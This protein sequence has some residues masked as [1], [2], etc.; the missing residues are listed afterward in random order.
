M[1][2]LLP[3]LFLLFIPLTKINGQPLLAGVSQV[4]ITPPVGYPHYRDFGTAVHDSLY[5]KAIVF[6]QGETA[7]AIAVCDLLWI[8]RK[9]SSEVRMAV[10]EKTGIPFDHILITATHTHTGPAYHSNIFELNNHLRKFEGTEQEAISRDQYPEK[11]VQNIS[12][13]LVKAYESAVPA[14]VRPYEDTLINL[15]FNRRYVM[16]DGKVR[17]NPG[18]GNREIVK[19]AGPVDPVL[20]ILRVERLDNQSLMAVI[21]NFAV[22]SD[23]FG[24]TQFSADYPGVL[25]ARLKETLGGNFVSIFLM[26]AS[27]DIN[28]IDVRPNGIKLTTDVIG[29][30]LADKVVQQFRK[31]SG[32]LLPS[33]GARSEFVYAPLQAYSE[34][35][36]QWAKDPDAPAKYGE[37]GL[38][39][40]RRPMKIR[41]LERIRATEAVP[42]TIDTEPWVLPVEVQVF[43][44]S[45]QVAVVGLPGEIFAELG[46]QI[47]QQ[48]P[49][50]TTLVV[51]LTNSHIAY[52]PTQKAFPQGGYETLNSRLAPGGGERMVQSAL[53]QLQK[54]K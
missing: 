30:R 10:A 23:T 43:K 47:K 2:Y 8:E 3:F 32:A 45:E 40:L 11:L 51:E 15:S 42:P 27:G 6:R 44:L 17:T 50:K 21:S 29:T 46:L 24:G 35:E 34:E 12:E 54:L 31:N 13:A 4:N 16:Q 33:L 7:W 5:V 18:R 22:H 52:V 48:S 38:F 41:S 36:L 49:F 25:A 9:L 14:I 19:P 37:T 20:N 26:G 53:Q 28:H 39:K 1:K